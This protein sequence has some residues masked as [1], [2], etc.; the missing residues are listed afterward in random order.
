MSTAWFCTIVETISLV[1]LHYKEIWWSVTDSWTVSHVLFS[2][3]KAIFGKNRDLITSAVV[4]ASFQSAE[5]QKC[6]NRTQSSAWGLTVRGLWPSERPQRVVA[7]MMHRSPEARCSY[8]TWKASQSDC[9]FTWNVFSFLDQVWT[10]F[11]LEF[12]DAP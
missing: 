9:N 10:Y 5:V 11:I 7:R 1:E 12:M 8:K 2:D 3:I 4:G 6:D